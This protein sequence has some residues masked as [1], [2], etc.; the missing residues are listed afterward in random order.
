MR[1]CCVPERW[2][3]TAPVELVGPVGVHFTALGRLT[4]IR[5]LGAVCMVGLAACGCKPGASSEAEPQRALTQHPEP[6]ASGSS[7]SSSEPRALFLGE[8]DATRAGAPSPTATDTVPHGEQA[9]T[10]RAVR[11]AVMGD[12]LTARKSGGGRFLRYLEERCPKSTFDNFGKGADMVNQMRRRFREQVLPPGGPRYTHIVVFG[13]VNDLYSDLTAKRTNPKIEA[14]LSEMYAWSHEAGAKVVAIAVTPWGGFT[15]YWNQRRQENTLALNAWMQQQ[16]G[17]LVDYFVDGHT[18]LGCGD[19][20]EK[21]CPEFAEPFKDGIHFGP[22]GHEVLG[23]ALKS[24]VFAD[25]L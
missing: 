8:S 16:R 12:S 5:L 10:P 25:C 15:K 18:L 1:V 23:E 17:T 4:V 21:L 3:S 24:Q 14:D 9:S 22:K 11:V 2:R 7:A 6:R 19:P 20:V 13:G